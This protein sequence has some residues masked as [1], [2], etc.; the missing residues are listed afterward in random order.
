MLHIEL[1]HTHYDYQDH[2]LVYVWVWVGWHNGVRENFWKRTWIDTRH[3]GKSIIQDTCESVSLDHAK[4]YQPPLHE[5][6]PVIQP[7]TTQTQ[8]IRVT[9]EIYTHNAMAS[10]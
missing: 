10:P 8:Y 7:S 4:S 6:D 3:K 5:P 2:H 1:P 9:S